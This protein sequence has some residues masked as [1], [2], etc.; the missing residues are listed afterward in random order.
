MVDVEVSRVE[1]A[2]CSTRG[3]PHVVP[4]RRKQ[5]IAGPRTWA[6]QKLQ[7]VEVIFGPTPRAMARVALGPAPPLLVV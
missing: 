4:S 3:R 6:G 7:R 5:E 1:A 2:R